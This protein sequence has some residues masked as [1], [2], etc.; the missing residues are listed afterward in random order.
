MPRRGLAVVYAAPTSELEARMKN[1]MHEWM[2]LGA[3]VHVVTWDEAHALLRG[4]ST[5]LW[6]LGDVDWPDT[7][8]AP[9]PSYRAGAEAA[10]KDAT[11]LVM[12]TWLP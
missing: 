4:G 11:P 3:P 9:P 1:R 10:M 7:G 12:P 6:L 8:P 2:V 5:P